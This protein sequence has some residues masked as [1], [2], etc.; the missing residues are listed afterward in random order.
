MAIKREITAAVMINTNG[1]RFQ[2]RRIEI[3][4][5]TISGLM[6]VCFN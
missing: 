3:P 4:I 5:Y 1:V 2:K 6:V